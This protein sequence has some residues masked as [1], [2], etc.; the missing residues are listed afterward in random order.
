VAEKGG[1][2]PF[3]MTYRNALVAPKAGVYLRGQ[4]IYSDH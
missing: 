3:G 1:T 2:L 4:P